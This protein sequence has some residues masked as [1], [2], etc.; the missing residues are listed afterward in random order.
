MILRN[1]LFGLGAQFALRIV[2]FLF[3]VLIIRTLGGEAY[4]QYNIVIAWAALFSVIG[5]LGINQYLAREIAREP[6]KATELFWDTVVLRFVLAVIASA[7]TIVGAATIGVS[8]NG[9]TREII[10]GVAIYTSSYFL[11]AVMAPLSSI[12]I[13]HERLDITST[14]GVITQVLFMVAAGIFLLLGL[15]FVWVVVASV[16]TLPIVT[17]LHYRAVRRNHLGPPRFKI[18]P[19]LWFAVIKAGFPFGLVQ[20]AL[21]FSFRI[22]TVILSGHIS[23]EQIGWY[24]AA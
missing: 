18:N 17:Y 12:L 10:L 1:S 24:N 19:G 14:L 21:S 5:D 22:D 7:I 20:L 8:Q 9:Y 15:N 2:G 3:N 23:D 6:K 4:G 16:V 13:G 11:Q